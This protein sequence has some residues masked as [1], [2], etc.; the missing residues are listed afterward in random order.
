[1]FADNSANNT[2]QVLARVLA[3]ETSEYTAH[4]IAGQQRAWSYDLG[5]L[6]HELEYLRWADRS[7][8]TAEWVRT[9]YSDELLFSEDW[10]LLVDADPARQFDGTPEVTDTAETIRKQCHPR[11]QPTSIYEQTEMATEPRQ[12]V[13]NHQ[14]ARIEA[15]LAS[16]R[17]ALV[18]HPPTWLDQL[19]PSDHPN[20]TAA[21]NRVLLWRAVADFDHDGQALGPAPTAQT[22][23]SLRTYYLQAQAAL[24]DTDPAV[25]ED[26]KPVAALTKDHYAVSDHLEDDPI[27]F[28]F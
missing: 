12:E 9:H 22:S 1:M 23:K 20:H 16:R 26:R 27:D 8:R 4:E 18:D 24:L 6:C 2:H 19:P 10:Q 28:A 5:R 3:N 15:E 7:Q 11:Q 17:A 13:M 14:V 25:P 21:L